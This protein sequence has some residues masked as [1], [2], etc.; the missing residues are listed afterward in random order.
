MKY[1]IICLLLSY[2]ASAVKFIDN[3]N[4]VE[5][6]FVLVE[7]AAKSINHESFE[8]WGESSSRDAEVEAARAQAAKND[9]AKRQ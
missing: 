3:H 2:S 1:T 5:N 8:S 6:D 9:E 7:P 4:V